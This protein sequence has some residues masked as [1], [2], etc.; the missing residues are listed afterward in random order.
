MLHPDPTIRIAVQ[1]AQKHPWCYVPSLVSDTPNNPNNNHHP[2]PNPNLNLNPNNISS[3]TD[4]C[5]TMDITLVNSNFVKSQSIMEVSESEME[6]GSNSGK[7]L[8]L[9]LISNKTDSY[10]ISDSKYKFI[11]IRNGRWPKRHR[12][13]I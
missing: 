3:M 13:F 9:F 5:N 6:D 7:I 12:R 10:S 4:S 1:D 11:L 8:K 2:H